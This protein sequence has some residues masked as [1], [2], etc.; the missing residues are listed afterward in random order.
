M[1]GIF[2]L[3]SRETLSPREI[4]DVSDTLMKLSQR[5]GSDASGLATLSDNR[6]RVLKSSLPAATLCR[7]K[8]YTQLFE[9]QG[10]TAVIGHARMETDGS[11]YAEQNNQPVVKDNVITVHNG[12][13][14]NNNRIWQDFGDISRQYEVDTEVIN[15]LLRKFIKENKSDII[16]AFQSV[17]KLLEG[18][19]SVASLFDDLNCLLLA[20]NTG[21]LYEIY[22]QKTG[23]HIFASERFFLKSLLKVVKTDGVSPS[24][25]RQVEPGSGVVINLEN[26]AHHAFPLFPVSDDNHKLFSYDQISKNRIKDT[27][28]QLKAKPVSSSIISNETHYAEVKKTIEGEYKANM[29]KI[30]NLKRCTK[31]LLTETMPFITFDDNG[32][33]NYCRSYQKKELRGEDRLREIT[34]RYRRRDGQPDCIVAYSGGRDSTFGLHY[35][36]TVLK[37]HPI[38]YTYDWGMLTDLGRRNIARVC[39]KLGVEN[40]LVSA[41][42][43]GKRENIRKNVN[44]WLKKP[45][46]GM[47]PLFM[48]GDKQFHYYDSRIKKDTGIRMSIWMTNDLEE[49]YFKTGFCGVAPKSNQEAADY[50]NNWQKLRLVCFYA[51]NFITNPRYLNS[52]IPDTLWSYYSYY[53]EPRRDLYQLYDFIPWDEKAIEKL[54]VDEYNWEVAPDTQTTWRIDDGTAPFYNYIYYTIA[55]FSE[56]DTFRSNQIR[57]GIISRDEGMKLVNEE[58][59]PRPDSIKWYCDTIGIDIKQATETINHGIKK[60]Y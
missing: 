51:T 10:I 28:G 49:T 26:L 9:A 32:V 25:V 58:N 6:I 29:E 41:N 21:S 27:V 7:S 59:R 40:I 38:A 52:S 42:I 13:I 55:G 17:F 12:I 18:S 2:G 45:H 11:S 53:I 31:C 4:K 30:A 48:A 44:A 1:C 35:I 14:V 47:V 33:C 57:E 3:T 36:K 34:E 19:F 20:T 37:L 43:Q 22:N 5:R 50:L 15:S 24:E 8:D 16:K 23:V 60:L 46:I 56:I 39:G 54:I